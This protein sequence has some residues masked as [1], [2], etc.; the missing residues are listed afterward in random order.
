MSKGEDITHLFECQINPSPDYLS[1]NE[2]IIDSGPKRGTH[3]EIV[4]EIESMT[5]DSIPIPGTSKS[6]VVPCLRFKGK[7]KALAFGTKA[8]RIAVKSLLGGEVEK[9]VGQSITLYWDS[10]VKFKG[11]TCGGIRIKKAQKQ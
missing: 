4:V 6:Q 10:S 9:W 11:K 7:H 3:R 1:E 2:F 8:K 5:N